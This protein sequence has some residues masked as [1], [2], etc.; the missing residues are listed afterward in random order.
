MASQGKALK[1]QGHNRVMNSD[2]EFSV[3]WPYNS[4][5]EKGYKEDM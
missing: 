3:S 5:Y 2:Q 1:A 4:L